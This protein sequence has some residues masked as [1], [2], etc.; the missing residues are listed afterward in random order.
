[1]SFL[2]LRVLISYFDR[3]SPLPSFTATN[4]VLSS[5]SNAYLVLN[6]LPSLR[7]TIFFFIALPNPTLYYYLSYC[8][9][10]Y[11]GVPSTDDS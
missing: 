7:D 3:T 4:L 11:L 10:V 5:S 6:I 1:M 8:S 9:T 2:P